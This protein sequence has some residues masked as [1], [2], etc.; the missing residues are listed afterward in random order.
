VGNFHIYENWQ[1]GPH[2]SGHSQRSCGTARTA[3]EGGRLRSKGMAGGSDLIQH[4]NVAEGVPQGLPGILVR[5]RH[6]W[7][8]KISAEPASRL[9]KSRAPVLCE[10]RGSSVVK[11]KFGESRP[12]H[13][14]PLNIRSHTLHFST[15]RSLP[16]VN[17]IHRGQSSSHLTPPILPAPIPRSPSGRTPAPSSPFSLAGPRTTARRPSIE[18]FAPMRIISLACKKRSRKLFP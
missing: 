9:Q 17:V 2:K 13:M 10:G 18:I 3:T 16:A 5:K 11:K 7:R 6:R 14:Q 8:L 1:A 4:W 12:R 15:I